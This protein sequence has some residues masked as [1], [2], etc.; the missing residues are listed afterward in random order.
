MDPPR[1]NTNRKRLSTA[2]RSIVDQCENLKDLH[3]KP[4]SK[5][6][7]SK[8]STIASKFQEIH[9]KNQTSFKLE[10]AHNFGSGKRRISK[11]IQSKN[12][13]KKVLSK[14]KL[15]DML[16]SETNILE[17]N[18]LSFNKLDEDGF[19]YILGN[20]KRKFAESLNSSFGSK[21]EAKLYP[22]NSKETKRKSF[23]RQKVL[24]PSFISHPLSAN[25]R[26]RASFI[27]SRRIS[28]YAAG[29]NDQ[30]MAFLNPELSNERKDVGNRLRA[31]KIVYNK[32]D[33]ER[34][35]LFYSK[36]IRK[37]KEKNG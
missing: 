37:Q 18:S 11:Y 15:E 7:E 36:V 5:S 1:Y 14:D 21:L 12:N 25:P 35:N 19:S 13:E 27:Q 32:H 4:L 24:R 16:L 17:S 10:V 34:K 3:I 33:R 29:I 20:N 31:E 2:L 22:R 30:V 28:R 8:I 26:P 9:P 6:I 23:R